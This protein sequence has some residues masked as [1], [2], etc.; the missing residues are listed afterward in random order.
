MSKPPDNLKVPP[1]SDEAERA[2]LGAVFIDP[3][4]YELVDA[5]LEAGDFYRQ[6]HRTIWRAIQK[7]HDS[8]REI[9]VLTVADVLDAD[10]DL[11]GVGG[12]SYLTS[13]SNETPKAAHHV[14]SYTEIV[15][16]KAGL[17]HFISEVGDRVDDA[18]AE[19]SDASDLV[20]G[21]MADL[22]ELGASVEQG[23]A[24][25]PYSAISDNI[26][27]QVD[28]W[29]DPDSDDEQGLTTGYPDI[30]DY[31]R[32]EDGKLY[33][34]GGRPGMGKSA[35]AQNFQNQQSVRRDVPT[36]LFSLEMPE[37]EVGLRWATIR[38]EVSTDTLQSTDASE[39]D[40]RRFWQ[41]EAHCRE[42]PLYCDDTP[43]VTLSHVRAE[44]RRIQA[45]AGLGAIYID[46]VQLM[47]VRGGYQTREQTVA[48]LS[49]G[50][51]EVAKDLGVPVVALAQLNRKLED[52]DDKRPRLADLRESGALEQDA[53]VV[54][55]LYRDAYYYEDS[56][57]QNIAEVLV[58]KN[59]SGSLGDVS[60]RWSSACTRFDS[61]ATRGQP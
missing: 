14:E 2:V 45:E 26:R 59:R 33:I 57:D 12:P 54:A 44:A 21:A 40:L 27:D 38:A 13:L 53:D 41:A 31:F 4:V 7:V 35:L 60:L 9:D 32:F 28:E 43:A 48:A 17:R 56:A 55:F 24:A 8:D 6:R 25:R 1:H 3:T 30:D 22:Q 19:R 11:E 52:R 16:N 29:Q 47:D 50:L 15:A 23:H 5:D 37:E 46:Y 49:R 58:R 34:L 42:A 36:L 61:L 39:H 10:D 18:Y 20:A 51:K